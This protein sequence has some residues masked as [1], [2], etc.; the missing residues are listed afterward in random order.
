VKAIPLAF[1]Q[2]K[3]ELA[4][5]F[6]KRKNIFFS[7]PV[8]YIDFAIHPNFAHFYLI[9]G[10]CCFFQRKINQL[11]QILEWLQFRHLGEKLQLIRVR[12]KSLIKEGE[13]PT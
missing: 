10:I 9:P 2:Y 6:Y 8:M 3:A 1:I 11:Q 12:N 13:K 4:G 7:C 5:L